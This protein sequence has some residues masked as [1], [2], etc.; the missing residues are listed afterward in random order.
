M[1]HG[2]RGRQRLDTA[3]SWWPRKKAG[4]NS[5]RDGKPLEALKP[6]HEIIYVSQRGAVIETHEECDSAVTQNQT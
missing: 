2:Q 1:K 6:Q 5:P 4:L 3:R